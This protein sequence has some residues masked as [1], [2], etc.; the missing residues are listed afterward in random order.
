MAEPVSFSQRMILS[1]SPPY[2]ANASKPARYSLTPSLPNGRADSFTLSSFA[3]SS[4]S[5]LRVKLSSSLPSWPH[6][7]VMLTHPAQANAA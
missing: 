2:S 7:V 4:L 1:L 3:R 5:S 6:S